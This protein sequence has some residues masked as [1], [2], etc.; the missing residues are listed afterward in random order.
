M[1]ELPFTED[2]INAEAREDAFLFALGG[3]AFAKSL[4][5]S[6]SAWVHF[7]SRAGT[8]ELPPGKT[9]TALDAA[10]FAALSMR[11]CNGSVESL[12]GD[13]RHAE[14][15]LVDPETLP[16]VLRALQ[17]SRAEGDALHEVFRFP[18]ES[19]GL[20]FNWQRE[21]NRLRFTFEKRS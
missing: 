12:T 16:E 13:E 17:L 8:T 14:T 5:Q 10:T 2:D 3:L 20:T 4:G 11:V 9:Y 18:A 21:G 19:R 7:L 15:V 1:A 6:P